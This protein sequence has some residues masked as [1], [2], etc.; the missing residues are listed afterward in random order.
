MDAQ[1]L[2]NLMV[3][4]I[5][6]NATQAGGDGIPVV[7]VDMIPGPLAG[8]WAE[9]NKKRPAYLPMVS[10]KNKSGEITAQAQ[11]SSYTPPTQMPPALA[12]ATAI[13]RHSY[14]ADH[15][16]IA[17]RKHAEQRRH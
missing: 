16:R 12:G 15:R 9:R 11:V 6:D 14:P 17:A 1:R 5:A 10:L 3:S 4:M 2:E 13:H 8:H 7:D